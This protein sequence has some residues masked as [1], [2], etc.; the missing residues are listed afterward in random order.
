VTTSTYLPKNHQEILH[1]MHFFKEFPQQSSGLEWVG[2]AAIFLVP[3]ITDST[4]RYLR[5]QSI[6]GGIGICAQL[7]STSDSHA[8]D[9][10]VPDNK[11]LTKWDE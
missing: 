4:T 3:G 10:W 9:R 7:I 8:L 5:S 1:D 11:K 6:D 2:I